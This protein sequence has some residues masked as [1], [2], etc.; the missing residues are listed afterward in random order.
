MTKT[1]TG[2]ISKKP[3][4]TW[5]S[6]GKASKLLGV[7]ESTLRHWADRR[8]IRT[9]RTSGGHRRFA[10]EDL[11]AMMSQSS[12]PWESRSLSDLK[13]LALT[14]IRRRLSRGGTAPSKWYSRVSEK[15]K[16]RQRLLGRRLLA[17]A[18]DYLTRKR[19]RSQA[20]DEARDIGEE[21]GIQAVGFGMSLEDALEAFL[22]FRSSLDSVAMEFTRDRDLTTR[23]AMEI[24]KQ[25]N[26]FTDQVL[27]ASIKAYQAQ[28]ADQQAPATA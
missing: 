26:A 14:K 19:G 23:Q 10:Q 24:Y 2:D 17:S 5:L 16:L 22:F 20:L 6:I 13:D 8:A 9:F 12:G 18:S 4:P 1:E 28:R 3:T 27:L 25:L 11:Y 15:Q 21:Y 7:N